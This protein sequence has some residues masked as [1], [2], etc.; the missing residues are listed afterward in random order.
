MMKKTAAVIE[1]EQAVA[2]KRQEI[3]AAEDALKALRSQLD[4]AVSAVGAAMR[5]AD[6]DLPQVRIVSVGW[7][8][9]DVT[10]VDVGVID[11]A[12]PGGMLIVR[13]I[14]TTTEYRFKWGGSCFAEK[15]ASW[16]DNRTELR[17]VPVEY[18]PAKARAAQQG[19][20]NG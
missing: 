20:A 10:N 16:L 11:R 18:L 9:G 13:R 15:G 7:R 4:D 5:A 2:A 8:S 6:A 17:D 1:A 12:T 19:A 3:L 14:G